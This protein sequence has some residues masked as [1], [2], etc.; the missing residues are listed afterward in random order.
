MANVFKEGEFATIWT[1]SE[2][3]E[4]IDHRKVKEQISKL[5]SFF[6]Q[7]GIAP[8]QFTTVCF[9]NRFSRFYC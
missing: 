4:N 1:I 2:V 7:S 3:Q 8:T 6:S 5:H 9:N